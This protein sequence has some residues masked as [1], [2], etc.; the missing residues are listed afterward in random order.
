MILKPGTHLGPYE[1]RAPLGTCIGLVGSPVVLGI[2]VYGFWVSLAGRP[3]SKDY[4][5]KA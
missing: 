4:L 2:A 3:L 5:L 1:I